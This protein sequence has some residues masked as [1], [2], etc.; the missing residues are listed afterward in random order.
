VGPIQ[1]GYDQFRACHH[2][3]HSHQGGPD[4]MEAYLVR[5]SLPAALLHALT[6]PEQALFRYLRHREPDAKLLG[7]LALNTAIFCAMMAMGWGWGAV[8]YNV[9]VRVGNTFTWLTFHWI[10]HHPRCTDGVAPLPLPKPLAAAWW[11]M[12]GP[13]NLAGSTHHELHH[14]YPSVPDSKLRELSTWLNGA[15]RS[16]AR[17]GAQR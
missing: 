1:F 15:A 7:V 14:A 5:G 2:S 4:D 3:H 6:Q 9:V 16:G 13:D 17:V 8:M 11:I 12:L 10:L